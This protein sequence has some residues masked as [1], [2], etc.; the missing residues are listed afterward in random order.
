MEQ[1]WYELFGSEH[2]LSLAQECA[3]TVLIFFYGLL[4]LH[5]SGRRTF[6]DWSAFDIILSIIIG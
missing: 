6:A 2:N 1:Y 3:R 4:L 5:L